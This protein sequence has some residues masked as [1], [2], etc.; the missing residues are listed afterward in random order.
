[1]VRHD[2]RCDNP[3]S[4]LYDRSGHADLRNDSDGQRPE[5][6]IVGAMASV[7]GVC[8]HAYESCISI[9]SGVSHAL[10]ESCYATRGS[11]PSYSHISRQKRRSP[12]LP[13]HVK[14]SQVEQKYGTLRG[15]WNLRRHA[16]PEAEGLN[17]TG[18]LDCIRADREMRSSWGSEC[19]P[20]GL[21]FGFCDIVRGRCVVRR[22][23]VERA[24]SS[25]I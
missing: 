8:H 13:G 12:S 23:Q 16:L 24:T 10:L 5:L 21:L 2:T 7:T 9:A 20:G 15:K 25:V 18:Q 4:V 17:W 19:E 1:M 22:A 11:V 14:S 6:R 3:V